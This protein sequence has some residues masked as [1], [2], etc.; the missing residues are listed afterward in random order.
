MRGMSLEAEMLLDFERERGECLKMM[1]D[2]S[3]GVRA[4]G[5]G[6]LV[7]IEESV[8]QLKQVMAKGADHLIVTG[9][10]TE[11]EKARY[12]QLCQ[13]YGFKAIEPGTN[14]IIR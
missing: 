11:E 1:K 12:S 5:E 10:Y 2:P 6:R 4:R 9:G 13:E 7:V 14:R 3:P 8:K